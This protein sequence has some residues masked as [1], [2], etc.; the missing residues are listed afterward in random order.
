MNYG[1]PYLPNLVS[2]FYSIVIQK[3]IYLL[4]IIVLLEKD[5]SCRHQDCLIRYEIG[6]LF[7]IVTMKFT[8]W[9]A[10]VLKK[11]DPSFLCT[12]TSARSP[13]FQETAF[14]EAEIETQIHLFWE[15]AKVK[16]FW[17][18]LFIIYWLEQKDL[19]IQVTKQNIFWGSGKCDVILVIAKQCIHN[20]RYKRGNLRIFA[21]IKY[22]N[23]II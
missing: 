10:G 16:L 12:C 20:V 14:C 23:I 21:F 18:E 1:S 6:Y 17:D 4:L 8:A 5:R 3:R 19:Q 22:H 13:L 7:L 9:R 15:C 11:A 2:I